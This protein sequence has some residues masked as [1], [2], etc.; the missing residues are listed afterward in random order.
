MACIDVAMRCTLY[1]LKA[2][3]AR[4]A[5]EIQRTVNNSTNIHIAVEDGCVPKVMKQHLMLYRP[6]T[7]GAAWCR[8]GRTAKYFVV[9]IDYL[10]PL[11]RRASCMSFS[12]ARSQ[13][14]SNRLGNDTLSYCNALRMYSAE[15]SVFKERY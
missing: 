2:H 5:L 9:P 1:L 14:S 6:L 7:Y 3:L 4:Q 11:S 8:Y 15:I 12:S 10:S 13:Y